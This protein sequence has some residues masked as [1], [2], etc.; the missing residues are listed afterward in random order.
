[1]NSLV[2]VSYLLELPR[3]YSICV[4]WGN[5]EGRLFSFG[6]M[7]CS[8]SL[9]TLDYAVIT[10]SNFSALTQKKFIV[11]F[12]CVPSVDQRRGVVLCHH[13]KQVN[14]ISAWSST[15]APVLERKHNESWTLLK[16]LPRGDTKHISQLTGQSE[17]HDHTQFKESKEVHFFLGAW[18]GRLI[19]SMVKVTDDLYS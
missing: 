8:I 10:T 15:S 14:V 2:T 7:N 18:K 16:Y 11:C 3:F 4:L 6:F 9:D 19:R 12:C 1:M 17:S 5:S 13:L